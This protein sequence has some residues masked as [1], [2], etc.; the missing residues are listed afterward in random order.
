MYYKTKNPDAAIATSGF[1]M[2]IQLPLNVHLEGDLNVDAI[3]VN[4]PVFYGSRLLVDVNGTDVANG[5]GSI[6]HGVADGVFVAFGAFTEDLDD[7]KYFS[8]R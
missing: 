2:L 4:L 8:H 7:F 6:L 5:L 3:L 1:I